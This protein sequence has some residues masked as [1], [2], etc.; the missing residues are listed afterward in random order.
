VVQV[1]KY[2]CDKC[3]K[4]IQ[5]REAYIEFSTPIDDINGEIVIKQSHNRFMFCKNC[6][7]FAWK[8]ALVAVNKKIEFYELEAKNDN[9]KK[10]S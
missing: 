2:Y 6:I 9:D 1:I 8:K 3:E 10:I 5:S 4:E 7:I